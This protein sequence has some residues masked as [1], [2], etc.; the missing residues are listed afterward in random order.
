[1][2]NRPTGT[3]TFLF[4]D[5]ENSTQLWEQHPAWMQT[6]FARQETII[7]AA[8][9]AHEG[10][11]Y[12]MIGDAFQVA[13]ATAPAALAAAVAAQHALV[14][15]AWGEPGPL[16]VRMALHTGVTEERG[17]D[18]LGPALNRVAR[19]LGVSLGGQI[20]ATQA[21]YELVRDH[22]PPEVRLVD[23]GEHR[24]KDL[25]RPEHIYQV[26]TPQLPAAEHALKTLDAFPHNLPMQVTSFIGR[27]KEISEVKRLLLAERFVTLTGPGGTGKT[28]LSLQIGAELL[29]LF[30][31]GVW[32][33]ELVSLGDPT[34]VVQT[35]AHTLGVRESSGRPLLSLMTN[36]LRGKDMLLILDNCE[37]LVDACA[38]LVTSLLQA[39]PTLFVLASSREALGIGGEVAYRVPSLSTPDMRHPPPVESMS[40]YEAV[41][42]FIERAESVQPGFTVTRENAPAIAQICH[43][44]E[45]IPLAI[46][47]AAVRIK[48][49]RVEQIAARLDDR[50]RLLTGGSRT[51]MPRHQTLRALIDWSY[52]LLTEPERTLL[53]RL[54]VFAGGWTLEAAEAICCGEGL[55]G[56]EVLDT[57]SQLVNKS[58]VL[59]D[60][61]EGVEAQYRLLETIRQYAR[62][63]LLEAGG[64]DAV[65]QRHLNY[66][67][68][69]AEE[70]EPHLRSAQQVTWL[71]RLEREVD[72]LRGA[73]EWSLE[74]E[75]EAGLR[76]AALLLWFW[77][78]R[79]HRSEGIEWLERVLAADEA[80]ANTRTA[81][82]PARQAA[83]GQ[84][85]NTAGALMVMHGNPE[86]G[87]TLA[88]K[89]LVLHRGLGPAGRRG[90]AMALWVTAQAASQHE[91][92]DLARSQTEE[93]LAL[94]RAE[95]DRFGIAQ[96]LDNLGSY[97]LMRGDYAAAK[98][99]WEEDL[100]LRKAL[101]DQDGVAWVLSCLA[102]LEF[103]RGN[104]ERAKTLFRESH[105]VF[106]QVNNKWAVSMALSGM[107]AVVLSEGNFDQA[108]EIYE[109]AL[110]YGREMGDQNTVAGRRY[111]LARV[112]WSRGDYDRAGALLEET[113]AHVRELDNEPGIAGTL[114][115]LAGVAWAL[116]DLDLAAQR[117][118]EAL[119]VARRI[120]A[121]QTVGA[122]LLGLA[123]V[124]YTRSDLARARTYYNE[125]LN[126][127][128]T[129]PNPWGLG[130][131]LD[132]GATLAL[133]EGNPEH[134]ALLLGAAEAAFEHL[135]YLLAPIERDE[136]ARTLAAVGTSLSEAAFDARLAEG[137][138][139]SLDQAIARALGP[140]D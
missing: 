38:Q 8:V 37:H 49:L 104:Y 29:E 50:F 44:L 84:A 13:F 5:I 22:L 113:L 26:V 72:N 17:D 140:Q 85:L 134:A 117:Y 105:E 127:V 94:Y 11:A 93:S 9:A 20:L 19:L 59:P 39:A 43:R 75:V 51:A 102:N 48:L 10:Y 14:A 131:A 118:E 1:M 76:L 97:A 65:R 124:A 135:R 68:A 15:E 61:A 69:L 58:L 42:L 83:R 41:R 89:S 34:L 82:T 66:F 73:L 16:R 110:A 35:V 77:H 31:D 138:A 81:A 91:S 114:Y 87:R 80:Q 109:E 106:R 70:A 78:I 57:L 108:A 21:T 99:I 23:L 100:V 55:E 129:S 98:H 54:S 46:E 18:Y 30:P 101:A 119:A 32:L 52:D 103:W 92:L 4:T 67:L 96:C 28:R 116:G 3:V 7:R 133:A 60:C 123:R 56:M 121:R 40:Q 64:G 137:R 47:L 122:T 33:V 111:D 132:A 120:G 136:H 86:T 130:F 71:D 88:E 139:M 12:K 107:G 27:E 25:I 95:G 62:E 126:L 6:A 36:Y 24:L 90:A 63:K 74:A 79:S 112:A 2:L 128:R 45:G 115:D 53:R 125:G